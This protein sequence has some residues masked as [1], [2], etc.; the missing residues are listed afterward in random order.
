ML[1]GV[2]EYE[3]EKVDFYLEQHTSDKDKPQFAFCYS[4]EDLVF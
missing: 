4:I 3:T 2:T 1:A